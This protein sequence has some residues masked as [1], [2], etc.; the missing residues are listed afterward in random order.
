MDGTWKED[1]FVNGTFINPVAP[2]SGPIFK[3]V[4]GDQVDG[5]PGAK[6]VLMTADVEYHGNSINTYSGTFISA[7]RDGQGKATGYAELKMKSYEGAWRADLPHGFG[8]A[9]YEDGSTYSGPFNEGR[10]H[11]EGGVLTTKTSKYEGFFASGVFVK[12]MGYAN[13]P[14][15]SHYEGQFDNG[16]QHGEGKLSSVDAFSY[17]GQ[18]VNG[19]FAKGARWVSRRTMPA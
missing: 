8:T 18:F 6:G 2:P 7:K 3:K 5:V 13:Y 12:G 1:S 19:V 15:G 9:E 11:G 10:H 4:V 17:V 14:D 16:K